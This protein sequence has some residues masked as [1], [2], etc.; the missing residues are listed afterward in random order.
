M[1]TFAIEGNHFTMN[2]EKLR[3]LSGTIH[4]FRVPRPYWRD[5]LLKLKHCGFNTVETYVAWNAHQMQP[6][7]YDFSDMLDLEAFVELA[8][9]VGLYVI[10]RPGPY[11]CAEWDFGGLPWW[12]LKDDNI[13][14]RCMDDIYL[15]HV[16]T[17]F[18][19]LIPKLAKHTIQKG[20]PIIAM[21]VENEYGSYGNDAVY[22]DYIRRGLLARGVD[23]ML[24]TSDGPTDWMLQ[25]GT[26]PDVF[27]T[28]NFGSR[29]ESDFAKLREY[30]KEG[31]LVCMEFWNGWFDHWGDKHHV[32]PGSDI[33]DCLDRMLKMDA[34]V[35][36]YMFHGGANYGYMAGANYAGELQPTV[37]NYD[38]DAPVAE[39]GTLTEKY[40]AVR[41]TVK[42]Y[43]PVEDVPLAPQVPMMK[44]GTV[45]M[46][47][48]A[49]LF[50]NL[51]TLATHTAA[52][53]P[54]PM[55]KVGQGYGTIL[56]RTRISGP[57]EEMP[58][59][60]MD[61]HDRAVVYI[62][63]VYQG[64]ILREKPS[65][66]KISVPKG[67]AILDVLVYADGRINYGP[68]MKDHKG[69]TEGILY[70]Q[71]FLYHYDIYSMPMFDRTKVRYVPGSVCDGPALY[72]GTFRAETVGDTFLATPVL[73]KGEVWV[74]GRHIGR[75]D[76]V[77]PQR[78]LYVPGCWLQEGENVV[79]I[80]DLYGDALSHKV[81]LIDH[82]IFDM[83]EV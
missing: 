63:G 43:Q 1:G 40:F 6:D 76:Q 18:D 60:L 65:Q 28:A 57:R 64:E 8:K 55:E 73:H 29:P 36:F 59:V 48:H 53:C 39:N 12:L 32:R 16:D 77:G 13:R 17:W 71:Q 23:C 27:K 51:D 72:R 3:I 56:Y 54:L 46:I 44:Y 47:E 42:K 70:G 34:S 49:P 82:A 10:V 2:G 5:R 22:L 52:T 35:N 20:G 11:I 25:G 78:T 66:V 58:L 45:E 81:E 83:E 61:V 67:G 24:F 62:D 9:E 38:Y 69:I 31:P 74:N 14:L 33:A 50:A 26:L 41:E 4:Y 37:S 75:V 21:Q 19:V 79:E 30:Q 15:G 7:T 80:F 68:R